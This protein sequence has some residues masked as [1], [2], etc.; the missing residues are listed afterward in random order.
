MKRALRDRQPSK[1][2]VDSLHSI[3]NGCQKKLYIY[4]YTGTQYPQDSCSNFLLT[5]TIY[6][7]QRH[8]S[9]HTKPFQHS[10]YR[11]HSIWDDRTQQR[12]VDMATGGG[13]SVWNFFP[14]PVHTPT[15]QPVE[16]TD[17]TWRRPPRVY[18]RR[19]KTSVFGTR[20]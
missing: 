15:R 19:H 12:I 9:I 3:T 13:R 7:K 2:T 14:W 6:M 16:D 5:I 1:A 20:L 10:E 4:I 17:R 8:Q 11:F 18:G